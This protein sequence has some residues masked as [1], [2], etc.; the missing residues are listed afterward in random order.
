MATTGLN[1][2]LD[3]PGVGQVFV[4]WRE[5][6]LGGVRTVEEVFGITSLR[7]EEA[8]ASELLDWTRRHWAIENQLF[9]VRDGTFGEDA[10]RV[11]TGG[12]A[13]ALAGL[14]NAVLHLLSK[15]AF[16]S[17]AEAV[18]HFMVHP[19]QAVELMRQGRRE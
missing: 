18:R 1:E 13:E 8:S 16:A 6:T 3:W 14:R 2:Y 17:K 19:L 7:P 12:A 5:R 15:T 10:C 9:G 4:L 11:R